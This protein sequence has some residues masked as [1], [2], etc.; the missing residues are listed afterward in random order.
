MIK[1][2]I[3][4]VG[5]VLHVNAHL[6][7]VKD[8]SKEF[9][10]DYVLSENTYKELIPLLVTGKITE[11]EFWK[12]FINRI[13]FAGDLPQLSL[14]IRTYNKNFKINDDVIMIVNKLKK[15]NYK[16]CVLS[17]TITA[18]TE[19]NKKRNIYKYFDNLI[20]SH[21]TGLSK[22]DPRFFKL[23]LEQLS[24]SAFEAVF[25]DDLE[26]N[27]NAAKSLGI[28]A[29][30]FISSDQLKSDLNKLGVNL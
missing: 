5:G 12:K 8:I 18:H 26:E 20:F 7:I 19:Y 25:I 13:Q 28:N 23:A 29:I 9:N 10:I 30:L 11:K 24:V 4:D 22:P 6:D 14:F 1:A 3:F 16:L 17:N 21:E 27:V 15:K 2:V